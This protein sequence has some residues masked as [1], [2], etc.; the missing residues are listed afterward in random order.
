MPH[1]VCEKQEN[2]Y[3][4]CDMSGGVDNR[5]WDKYSRYSTASGLIRAP[6][7]VQVELFVGVLGL[8]PMGAVWQRGDIPYSR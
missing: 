5:L 8:W 2:G 4:L 6:I 7:Q 3:G 1:P